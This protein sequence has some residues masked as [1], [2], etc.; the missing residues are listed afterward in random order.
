MAVAMGPH[1]AL[2]TILVLAVL[3]TA[4]MPYAA[5]G[6]IRPLLPLLGAV[7]WALFRGLQVATWWA[8]G[9]GL[10]L[11]ILSGSEIGT[12]AL[13]LAL[14]T[15]LASLAR[16]YVHPRN[17]LLLPL[18]VTLGTVGFTLAQRMLI[19]LRGGAVFWA[20]LSLAEDLVLAVA[21]NLLWLPVLYLPLRA[22]AR[23]APTTID[24]AG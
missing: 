15:L 1:A 8:L 7:T 3:Q 17:P 5:L 13:P 12:Y 20:G 16:R 2:L 21:L 10:A 24:W 22:V 19:W 9:A 11:D 4:V 14:A 23:P 18:M 6:G